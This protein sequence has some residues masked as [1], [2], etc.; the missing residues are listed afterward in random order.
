[1]AGVTGSISST[2]QRV[3]LLWALQDWSP[4]RRAEGGEEGLAGVRR[5]GFHLSLTDR[6]EA[7]HLVLRL[8]SDSHKVN[9]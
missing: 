8:L 6:C 1:M 2:P 9:N 3:G 5:V 7:E 4:W